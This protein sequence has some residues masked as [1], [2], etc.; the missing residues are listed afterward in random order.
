MHSGNGEHE[1]MDARAIACFAAAL[2]DVGL[3][4]DARLSQVL[5]DYF[6]WATTMTMAAYPRS[7]D[8]VPEHL[9]IPRWSWDGLQKA[10]GRD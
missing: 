10:A 8:D 5:L 7:P 2:R 4:E 3:Y 6:T 9:G 1:E